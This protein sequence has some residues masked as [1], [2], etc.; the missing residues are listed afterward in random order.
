LR[1]ILRW[2]TRLRAASEAVVIATREGFRIAAEPQ[3]ATRNAS[4]AHSP[5]GGELMDAATELIG[6]GVDVNSA[7]AGEA[8]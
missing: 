2:R 4:V 6:S 8:K 1:V 3:R 5:G 7:R